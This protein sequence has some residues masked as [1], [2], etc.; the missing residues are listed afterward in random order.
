MPWPYGWFW[1]AGRPEKRT[2]QNVTPAATRSSPEWAASERMPRLFVQRPTLSFRPVNS[3]AAAID[4]RATNRFSRS[5]CVRSSAGSPVIDRPR[6]GTRIYRDAGG[7]CKAGENESQ[8]E[9]GRRA[10]RNPPPVRHAARRSSHHHKR[11]IR[12]ITTGT[13]R[14]IGKSATTDPRSPCNP[15]LMRGS[16]G[17]ISP[18]PLPNYNERKKATRSINSSG[19]RARV[20]PCRS[21]ALCAVRM[22]LSVA[23]RPSC[24]YGAVR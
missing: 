23:A 18:S 12:Q 10:G 8:N 2:A 5:A 16:R 9:L 4:E 20:R 15:R 22:S 11:G 21:S 24:R 19:V 7:P 1:S 3:N 6:G 14:K 13:S 17:R